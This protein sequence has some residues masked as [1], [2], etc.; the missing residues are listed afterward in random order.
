MYP[1]QGRRRVVIEGV[2]PEVDGGRFAAKRLQGDNL[3]VQADIFTDGHDLVSAALLYRHDSEAEWSEAAMESLPNDRWRAAVPLPRLGR[4]RFTLIGWVDHFLTWQTDLKKKVAAGQDVELQLKIGAM[5]IDAAS[6][7]A[8]ADRGDLG[9]MATRLRAG[10]PAAEERI[11]TALSS[12]LRILMDRNPDVSFATRYARELLVTVDPPRAG[13]SSW[14]ELFPRSAGETGT[15]G[16]FADVE[17]RILPYIA[18]MGFDVLYFPPIHPIGLAHR[19]G[20]NNTATAES[21]DV[22]S[23]WGIGSDA[24]G[25]KS[26]VTAL[27]TME[28][29]H[30]LIKTARKLGIDLALD[31]AF[32]VSPDHPYVQSHPD[33]FQH[34]PDGSIQYAEN[35]PKK[36]QD[37]YPFNFDSDDWVSLWSELVDVFHFWIGHGITIFRV[38]NPHTKAL[39]FWEWAIEKIKSEHPEVI[40]LSEAFT[41]P[42]IMFYLA[43]AGFTQSYTYFAWRNTKA[44]LT[45]YFTE[46][47]QPPVCEFFRPNAWPNT[48]D[49]LTEQLQLGGRP[50]FV[51]RMI[52]AATLSANYGIY[53]PAYEL[54]ENQPRETG[55]EEYLNSEKY[56]IRQW[57][58]QHP[59]SLRDMITRVNRIRKKNQALHSDRSLRFHTSTS[60]QLLCYS[61]SSEDQSNVVLTVVNLDS[62]K[63]SSGFV[64]LDLVELGLEEDE[65]FQV[66]DLISDARYTWRGS[67]NYVHLD[68]AI[69]PAHIFEI[70][71]IPRPREIDLYGRAKETER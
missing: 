33:W 46:I 11:D 5:L 42:K 54:G 47:T 61:K 4:Y 65:I 38:D 16:T 2:Q 40:L 1:E 17:R 3:V 56:E 6:A 32:Q 25:H 12:D 15:H 67:R 7:R 23:P 27:G 58:L 31:I 45:E 29:L 13:F 30:S 9:T 48:P 60:E 37:I 50:A 28:D 36:Y 18:S 10:N 64:E 70:V 19:K 63:T 34:R 49:I 69:I 26:I 57:D 53:G 14:Y 62:F 68:P 21:S 20:K 66:H 55:S 71:R 41:R 22:G 59:E 35:P 51:S 24:G 8:T 52:L 43:K 44:E 39:P